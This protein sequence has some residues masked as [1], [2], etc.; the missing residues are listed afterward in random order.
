MF[1][2]EHKGED[3]YSVCRSSFEKHDATK[4]GVLNRLELRSAM[5]EMTGSKILLQHIE[6]IFDEFDKDAN[7]VIDSCEYRTI[8]K[9]FY[10]KPKP[11]PDPEPQGM[12]RIQKRKSVVIEDL[13][14]ELA[15]LD[16]DETD[17]DVTKR[18]LNV[19]E[20]SQADSTRILKKV[21]EEM[22]EY[23]DLLCIQNSVMDASINLH[24]SK[25][26]DF[27]RL[28][29]TNAKNARVDEDFESAFAPSEMRCLALV[30]HNGMKK[31]MRQFVLS[32]K[33]ILKKF[34]LT[35]TNSTMTMLKEVF[36]DE[37][38]GTVVFGPSCASGPLGGD[39]ELVAHLVGGKIGG[40]IFFQDP[41]DS[42]PHRADIDCL[43]RQ[44][45]VYNT[46]M[47]ETPCTALMLLH[48]LRLALKGEGQPELIPSF[49]FS[50][51]S[52]TVEAYKSNQKKVVNSHS[53][54]EKNRRRS[55]TASDRMACNIPPMGLLEEDSDEDESSNELFAL[56][57][58]T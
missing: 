38:K 7:G 9:Y 24:S 18:I 22:Y 50:L 52:P 46:M 21:A 2:D 29:P 11:E 19:V 53:K 56:D 44:A 41:M 31:S 3:F 27:D 28:L 4:N 12:G 36:K 25:A 39:A 54:R 32:N 13:I 20:K 23:R 17:E 26:I 55:L 14:G 5:E 1:E 42:H 6:I 16:V 34:R 49:F 57:R 48:T 40:I 15:S 45:L 35:G 33:N 10:Q 30:S 51:L 58:L 43:A 47:V 37:P 8:M